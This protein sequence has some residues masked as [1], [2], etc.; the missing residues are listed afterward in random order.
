MQ[1]FESTIPFLLINGLLYYLQSAL[2]A[3]SSQLLHVHTAPADTTL[4]CYQMVCLAYVDK[5]KAESLFVLALF[6][7]VMHYVTIR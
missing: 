4:T 3:A 1:L 6:G 7:H 2:V 5:I